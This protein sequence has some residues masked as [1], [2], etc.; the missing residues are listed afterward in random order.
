MKHRKLSILS[1]FFLFFLILVTSNSFPNLP[2]LASGTKVELNNEISESN[3]HKTTFGIINSRIQSIQTYDYNLTWNDTQIVLTD[4][5]TFN[6]S[7]N[8]LIENCTIFIAPPDPYVHVTITIGE[9]SK[10]NITDSSLIVFSGYG[11]IVFVGSEV[12]IN[13]SSFFGFGES[14]Y[15]PGIYLQSSIISIKNSSFTSGYHGIVF[16]DSVNFE[17]WNCSF[18]DINGFEGYGGIGLLGIDSQGISI[19]QC[20]FINTR[21]SL[22]FHNCRSITIVDIS[23]NWGVIGVDIFPNFLHSEV[24]D[25]WIENCTFQNVSIGVRVIGTDITIVNNTFDNLRFAGLSVGGRQINIQSNI[26]ENSPRGIITPDSLVST[27]PNQITASSISNVIIQDNLFTNISRSAIT[28]SNY[29]YYTLFYIIQNNFTDIRTGIEFLGNLGGRNEEER[30]LVAGNIFTNITEYAI[31]GSSLNYLAHFQYCSFVQNAFLNSSNEEYTS[32]QS[33]YYYMDD[34]RWDDGFLGNFW[35]KLVN[36]NPQDEDNNS[37]GDIFHIVSIDHG[38]YDEAPLLLL[39]F[40]LKELTLVS[41]HPTDLVRSNSELKGD[42]ATLIWNIIANNDSTVLVYIDGQA[43]QVLR[44]GSDIIVSLLSL[45]SGSHN[46][47]LVIQ[48]E[49]DSYRDLVWVRILEDEMDIVQ[50]VL[51]PFGALLFVIAILAVVVFSIKKKYL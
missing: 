38:Q 14:D 32:F 1:P 50:D 16:A 9:L 18:Q 4:S 43:T 44:N 12:Y 21:T 8:L 34:I 17:I 42:N 48:T 27:D 7:T 37:I 47:S 39:D 46:I 6:S 15:Q 31:E 2:H 23:V 10:L 33:R 51:V 29:E 25:I 20:S 11:S 35:Q 36:E 28:L 19:A 3:S 26:F 40:V 5:L 22:Y 30:S 45:S 13:N 24:Y 41:D 49:N